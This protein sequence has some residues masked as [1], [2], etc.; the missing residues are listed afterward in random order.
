MGKKTR[1]F[2]LLLSPDE[3]DQLES[4][5]KL[6]ERSK[7]GVIRGLIWRAWKTQNTEERYCAGGALCVI[8]GRMEGQPPA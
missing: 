8:A 6:K 7:G 5:S 4:L 3:F 1:S 2:N